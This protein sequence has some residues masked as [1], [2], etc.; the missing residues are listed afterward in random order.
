MEFI[1]LLSMDPHKNSRTVYYE[2]ICVIFFF[3]TLLIL[4]QTFE[5]GFVAAIMASSED[6]T[7]FASPSATLFLSRE[8]QVNEMDSK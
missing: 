8:I 5:T 4:I 6:K 1:E 3:E 2:S 7:F